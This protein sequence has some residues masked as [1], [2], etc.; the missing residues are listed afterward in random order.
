MNKVT[1]E[2]LKMDVTQFETEDVITTS[3]EDTP[4]IPFNP[5][6]PWEMPVGP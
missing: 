2:R 5:N 1:Y 4:D 3:G 6:N